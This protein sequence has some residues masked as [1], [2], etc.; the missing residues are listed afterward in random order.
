MPDMTT[1]QNA[2][3]TVPDL[4]ITSFQFTF[5]SRPAAAN[6][7]PSSKDKSRASKDQH[8]YTVIIC[9]NSSSVC[10]YCHIKVSV[11]SH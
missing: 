5:N 1:H 2:Q 10:Q 6:F 4:Q 8:K 3:P 7:Q 11:I 9:N